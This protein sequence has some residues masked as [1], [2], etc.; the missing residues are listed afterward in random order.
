M[1]ILKQD[2]GRRQDV[3][4]SRVLNFLNCKTDVKKTRTKMVD[5]V[6]N[7]ALKRLAFNKYNIN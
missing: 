6:G 2:N 4:S 5:N 3:Y 1:E 7:D